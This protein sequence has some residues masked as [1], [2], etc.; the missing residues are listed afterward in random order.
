VKANPV[1]TPWVSP[2]ENAQGR[3]TDLGATYTDV[4]SQLSEAIQGALNAAGNADAVK[5]AF[6]TAAGK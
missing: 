2:I 1:W 4:S 6:Q 3:T 5:A